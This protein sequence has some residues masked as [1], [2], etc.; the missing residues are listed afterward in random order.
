MDKVH[1]ER[2]S[3]SSLVQE[4]S[5][6]LEEELKARAKVNGLLAAQ[7]S[8]LVDKK[9]MLD[10]QI[11]DA[12]AELLLIHHRVRVFCFLAKKGSAQSGPPLDH[13]LGA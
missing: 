8:P 10:Q 11:D 5:Q 12:E 3:E 13:L 4:L 6:L 9:E 1:K 7:R 2:V